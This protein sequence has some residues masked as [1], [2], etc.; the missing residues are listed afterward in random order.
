M[1]ITRA[2][3]ID[4]ST[5]PDADKARA[6]E[7]LAAMMEELFEGPG[8]APYC[9]AL[10]GGDINFFQIGLRFDGERLVAAA[11]LTLDPIEGE[12]E[13]KVFRSMALIRPEYQ[14]RR[15][16][17]GF[18]IRSVATLL[19][20]H[21]GAPIWSFS[22]AQHL[23]SYRFL[24]RHLHGLTP[25]PDREPTAEE[26]DRVDRLARKFHCQR[27]PTDHPLVC[28]RPVW[29]KGAVRQAKPLEHPMD[30]FGRYFLE[31]NPNAHE[32]GCVMTLGRVSPMTVLSMLATWP[33][34]RLR[35]RLRAGWRSIAAGTGAPGFGAACGAAMGSASGRDDEGSV[36]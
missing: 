22:P 10:R 8:I 27:L 20:R 25:H 2:E 9:A 23:A 1:P 31:I 34:L 29:L 24:A 7:A 12:G 3:T 15:M 14:G 35:D 5:A 26:L 6:R 36:R 17:T 19:W 11:T 21:R 32:G 28:R 4:F 13:A 18:A 30:R 33:V 16:L